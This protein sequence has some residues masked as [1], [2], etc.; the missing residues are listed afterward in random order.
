MMRLR[1][2]RSFRS[3]NDPFDA[4]REFPR[5]EISRWRI[6]FWILFALGFSMFFLWFKALPVPF[7]KNSLPTKCIPRS[8]EE[9]ASEWDFIPPT[10]EL[11]NV[12]QNSVAQTL[13][14]Q[15][16]LLQWGFASN[17]SY[18]AFSR[19]LSID[20]TCA[21]CF[22]GLAVSVSPFLNSVG[23]SDDVRFPHF[24][25]E[26]NE[27]GRSFLDQ[28]QNLPKRSEKEV[29]YIDAMKIRFREIE[30]MKREEQEWLEFLYGGKMLTVWNEDP[31]DLV[32]A[33]LAAEAFANR[34]SWDF[35][36]LHKPTAELLTKSTTWSDLI[37]LYFPSNDKSEFSIVTS[38][39][40]NNPVLDS[41]P[42]ID[43]LENEVTDPKMRPLAKLI[44]YMLLKILEMDPEHPLA[45]HLH[46]HIT[47]ASLEDGPRHGLSSAFKLMEVSPRWQA[48][49]LVHMPSHIFLRVGAFSKAIQS[50]KAAHQ[51]DIAIS[52]KC[53]H[54][55]APEHNLRVLIAAASMGGL[56]EEAERYAILIRDLPKK[57]EHSM[58]MSSGWN[59]V[60]L[61]DV[62]G[63]FGK[64]KNILN[65][66]PPSSEARGYGSHG[67]MEFA[68]THFLF[69]RV[70]AMSHLS[71]NKG[72]IL[73]NS[74]TFETVV[75]KFMKS[76][77]EVSQ[78][79]ETRPGTG[80]GIHS[81]ANYEKTQIAILYFQARN[82]TLQKDW[83][84]P[85]IGLYDHLSS[86]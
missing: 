6:L 33:S 69:Y 65:A 7:G 66:K 78:E 52:E 44:E 62:W 14:N 26:M 63:Q 8:N 34:I 39:S 68:Y 28:A 15:G 1:R 22:W 12:S 81:S 74:S 43:K 18:N 59:Y 50:N 51:M 25:K 3:E 9:Q 67:G 46:I 77:R 32:A 29:V 2:R 73:L 16:L 53:E 60:A 57:I 10:I 70:M 36:E 38:L 24:S 35:Y 83:V 20:A 30:K 19:S 21:M 37:E 64:W 75:E 41:I 17:A 40:V 31:N 56:Y 86:P 23:Q 76:A 61:L 84:N 80:I 13:F 58:Y 5:D 4:Q 45:L 54:P 72:R 55:Y 82:A 79:P 85:Q 49:H 71:K 27:K 47:E 48:S 11:R 42:K